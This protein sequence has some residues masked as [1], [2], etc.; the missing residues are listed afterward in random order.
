MAFL[1]CIASDFKVEMGEIQLLTIKHVKV[2]SKMSARKR[3]IDGARATSG[4]LKF[5]E[6]D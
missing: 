6:V 5:F 3:I 1:L 4:N 2:F